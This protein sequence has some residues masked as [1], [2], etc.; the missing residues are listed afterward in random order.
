MLGRM[1]LL[2]SYDGTSFRGW[3]DVRDTALRPALHRVMGASEPPLVEA[4]SRTDAGV[5]ARGQVC[6]FDVTR[7]LEEDGV[8]QLVYSLNQLL[9]DEIVVREGALVD[10]SAFDVRANLGKEYRY[11]LSTAPCSDPLRRLHEWHLPP[12]RGAAAWDVHAVRSAA[13][14][15]V[16]SHSFGAFGNTPR[17]AERKLEVDARCSL[18]MLQVR[19]L[20]PTSFQFRL[21]GDR[22]LY[23][24]CRNLVGALVK[25]GS[26]E[27]HAD[28]LAAALAAGR[29]ERSRSV[30][31]TAPA[32]GLVLHE[33]LYE[34]TPFAG[35][36]ACDSLSARDEGLLRR[37][38]RRG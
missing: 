11:G 26:G 27:L 36:A 34:E 17:G 6:S 28:E 32:H 8:P 37:R 19:Q 5:H 14:S 21:R 23:K 38:R 3:N 15:L 2:V 7:P 9:P 4:A 33:V 10:A 1:A 18:R 30:P 31:L 13:R 35:T 29:F 20:G 24:M 25:V 12:R 16:G 22:F